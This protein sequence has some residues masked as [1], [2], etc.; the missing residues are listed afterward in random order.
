MS[1]AFNI[2]GE[3]SDITAGPAPILRGLFVPGI[4]NPLAVD[5]FGIV[6]PWGG[7]STTRRYG[8]YGISTEIS[9]QSTQLQDL[10]SSLIPAGGGE[11]SYGLEGPRGIQGLQ[12]PQGLPGIITILG[13][14]L[15]QNS[16][17]VA[18]LPHNIDQLNQLGTAANKL[19]YTSVYTAFYNF[20]WTITDIVAIN[21]WN[22]SDINTDGS[23]FIIV[24]DAGI[25][26]S[27][28]DGDSWTTYTPGSDDYIQA[29]CAASGGRALVLGDSGRED[30]NFWYTDDYG[31]NWTEKTVVAE[32]P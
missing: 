7:G 13:L 21:S 30:G 9:R 6:T 12:G 22:D 5:G 19:T 32:D 1:E 20:V 17:Y 10:A 26:V 18:A 28:N 29:S 16:D 23:F 31:A 24:A 25:Y 2:S 15:P 4:D 8:D 27:V 11:V 14:N 3:S